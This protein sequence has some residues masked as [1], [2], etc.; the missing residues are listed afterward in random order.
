MAT[1]PFP[2]RFQEVNDTRFRISLLLQLLSQII[3][4]FFFWCASVPAKEKR[5]SK[6]AFCICTAQLYHLQERIAQDGL[7]FPVKSPAFYLCY[8]ISVCNYF[9]FNFMSFLTEA[10]PFFPPCFVHNALFLD[11]MF[12]PIFS[13]FLLKMFIVP[14]EQFSNISLL[15]FKDLS[16][17][18]F[19][20]LCEI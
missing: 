7:A 9:Y 2:C 11:K 4:F 15:Y 14:H 1:A 8:A 18:Y 5:R 10:R 6:E 3:F 19:I 16:L 20:C 12:F 17:S 13:V